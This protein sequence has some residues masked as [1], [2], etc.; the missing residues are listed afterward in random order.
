MAPA[1]RL[2]LLFRPLLLS[3]NLLPNPNPNPKPNPSSLLPLL[4]SSP[5]PS[6]PHPPPSPLPLRF[7]NSRLF[8]ASPSSSSKIVLVGSAE[9]FDNSLKR[10]EDEKLPA[11]FYF[12]AAWCGPCRFISP[13]IEK[14]G[15]K[16]PHV[17]TYKI[18]ID[19]E[20]LGSILNKLKIYSVPTLHFFQNGQKST[21]IVGADVQKLEATMENL[22]K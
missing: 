19:Q 21:E 8:S 4:L 11:I 7:S 17:T 22:Y 12:T 2:P 13:V 5:S 14:M 6:P 3:K 16:F 18:D 9:E 1:R 20:G 10:V 15:G